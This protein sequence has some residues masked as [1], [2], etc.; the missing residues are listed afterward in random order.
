MPFLHFH[1]G[2][3]GMVK[4]CCVAN[5]PFGNINSESKKE[6]WNGDEINKLR[7]KFLEGK[8]DNRCRVCLDLEASGA[9]SIRQETFEKF[10]DFSLSS[11]PEPIYFDIRFSNVC[12]FRCRTCWHGASSKWFN[13]AKQLGRN[14]RNKAVIKNIDDYERFIDEYGNALLNA[15]EIY[16]AGGEPLVT[17]EHYLLLTYLIKNGSMDL[18]LRYNTN[19]SVLK[20]KGF[21]VIE[22]WK[23]F[24]SVEVMASV[25]ASEEAG[26]Y[27]RKE[28]DWTLFIEN[29]IRIK[30]LNHVIFK[31]S[32]TVSV[33]NVK[34]LPSF[35]KKMVSDEIINKDHFYINLLH[36]PDYFNIQI[37]PLPVK[38]E[39]SLIYTNFLMEDL[40]LNIKDSFKEI[41][42]F[43]NARDRSSLWSKFQKE[44]GLLD[45]LRSE[46]P[47][48]A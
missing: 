5:I 21:D 34:S 35:Y 8:S 27:I 38:E 6:I 9:K 2:D 20:F 24:S 44:S 23:S 3:R 1:V 19:C 22:L 37:L 48:I 43:M 14:L 46:K 4:A 30:K 10:P 45:E 32:P 42:E 29:A 17:E 39:I 16:F 36:R 13:D 11:I 26:E 47:I 12:N 31:I 33:Y 15:K 7:S 40:P 41:L 18:R 28:L 25:D